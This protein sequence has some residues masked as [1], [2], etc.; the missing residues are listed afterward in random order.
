LVVPRGIT[1]LTAV[2]TAAAA[3][4]T[5]SAQELDHEPI[6][7]SYGAPAECPQE[8]AFVQQ[9]L[10]RTSRARVAE[11]GEVGRTFV[12]TVERRDE[13]Y[14]GVLMVT[15]TSGD[16]SQR[17]V[18]AT[19]CEEVVSALGLVTALTID[20]KATILP[21]DEAT[22]PP[23]EEVAVAEPAVPV[24]PVPPTFTPVPQAP[25]PQPAAPETVVVLR[26]ETAPPSAAEPAGWS[27]ALGAQVDLV[28]AVA[29]DL[30][31]V[32]R[33]YADAGDATDVLIS[34][35]A[36]VSIGG[37]SVRTDQ[38]T[39]GD[40]TLSWL[41]L[42]L[43]ACPLNLTA[44]RSFGLRPCVTFDVGVLHGQGHDKPGAPELARTD[45]KTWEWLAPG[46]LLRAE[47][48]PVEPLLLRLEGG[49]HRPLRTPEFVF[50]TDEGEESIFQVPTVGF[51]AGLGVGLD[52]S[53]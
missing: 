33:V 36:G 45:S 29:P 34:P 22:A 50:D 38:P 52:L 44:S 14:W 27:L 19:S 13:Q 43:E 10:S 20:P 5:I 7:V 32:P 28:T 6:R 39:S 9:V 21:R 8:Q 18:A 25:A 12:I 1:V 31:L 51:S 35:R 4:G 42:R 40:A 46:L 16:S 48:R 24:E 47:V 37:W 53:L 30:L 3:T 23:P 11:P 41:A 26:P 17:E 15:S 49:A 2:A